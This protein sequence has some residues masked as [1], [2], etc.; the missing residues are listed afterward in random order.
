MECLRENYPREV[1][2]NLM[3]IIGT[4]DT[5]R[6]LTVLGSRPE[7]WNA[8]KNTQAYTVLVGDARERAKRR[9]KMA[10][11]IQFCMPGSPTI[12]YGDEAGMQGYG[13][14]LNRRTFPWGHED[15]E[16]LYF[17]RT[18]CA[19]RDQSEVL[20]EG[21]LQFPD[22]RSRA[23]R[24][25]AHAGRA[26]DDC[27]GSTG[28]DQEYHFRLPQVYAVDVL[29]GNPYWEELG[30]GAYIDMQPESVLLLRCGGDLSE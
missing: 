29:T 2:Y 18:L 19:E 5:A 9:L 30:K 26:A 28:N 3:N 16:L 23:P 1:F 20:R 21:E 8:D 10:A 11:V 25:C 14:P 27:C 24:I 17:Y 6:A 13:D 22:S 7:L 12:Y 15:E 4:H